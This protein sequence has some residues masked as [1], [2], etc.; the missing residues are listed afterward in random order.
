MLP[1]VHSCSGVAVLVVPIHQ[2][3][4]QVVML[5]R[6]E[7]GAA[8][9]LVQAEVAHNSKAQCLVATKFPDRTRLEEGLGH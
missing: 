8:L 1:M 4:P 7:E 5:H 2:E 3:D 6:L 9:T